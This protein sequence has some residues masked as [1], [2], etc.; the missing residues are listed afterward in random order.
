M[1]SIPFPPRHAGAVLEAAMRAADAAASDAAEQRRDDLFT[2]W[3]ARGRGGAADQAEIAIMGAAL[4]AAAPLIRG[5][6][7]DAAMVDVVAH[8]M[9]EE[10]MTR[11]RKR[12]AA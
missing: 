5:L 9:A 1:T 8:G 4:H 12:G 10:A 2:P 11:L 6:T 7:A 3:G